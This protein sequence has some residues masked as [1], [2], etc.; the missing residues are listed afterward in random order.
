[1]NRRITKG[2][3]TGGILG[4]T[5][6]V[7]ALGKKFHKRKIMKNKRRILNRALAFAKGFNIF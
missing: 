4:I 3:I 6:A 7:Y 2:I 5:V 1:M